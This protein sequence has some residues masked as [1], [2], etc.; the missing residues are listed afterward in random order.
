MLVSQKQ[1]IRRTRLVTEYLSALNALVLRVSGED[2]IVHNFE[3][4]LSLMLF[5]QRLLPASLCG[6]NA[7]TVRIEGDSAGL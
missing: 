3:V 5:Q 1:G 6:R 7:S 4:P 2:W